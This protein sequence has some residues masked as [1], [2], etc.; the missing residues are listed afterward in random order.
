M[1][2]V[3]LYPCQRFR[4]PA[5]TPCKSGTPYNPTTATLPTKQRRDIGRRPE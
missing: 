3:D 4:S 5:S 1:I 2:G